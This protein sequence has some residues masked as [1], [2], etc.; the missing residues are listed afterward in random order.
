VQRPRL[1]VDVDPQRV[2]A[3]LPQPEIVLILGQR[4]RAGRLLGDRQRIG[5]V[6]PRFDAPAW[7]RRR[8]TTAATTTA[9]SL[10]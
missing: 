6:A 9:A 4:R 8:Q 1:G 10:A 5:R 7:R 3:A 2:V